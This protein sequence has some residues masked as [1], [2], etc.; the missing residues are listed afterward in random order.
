MF[1]DFVQQ[2]SDDWQ[3]I[4]NSQ[5]SLTAS[6]DTIDPE[7]QDLSIV[8]GQRKLNGKS[9]FKPFMRCFNSGWGRKSP[10]TKPQEES[11]APSSIECSKDVKATND[12]EELNFDEQELRSV[13]CS[14]SGYGSGLSRSTCSTSGQISE[15][16]STSNNDTNL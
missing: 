3:R 9:L 6:K 15:S 4:T 13:C 11:E 7:L 12:V 8:R 1:C 5:P 14:E 10:Y 2:K 16:V